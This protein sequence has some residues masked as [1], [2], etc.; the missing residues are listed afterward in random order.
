MAT[1]ATPSAISTAVAPLRGRL[2]GFSPWS[3]EGATTAA[4]TWFPD[5]APVVTDCSATVLAQR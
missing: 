5:Q 2:P 1:A 3:M 4:P